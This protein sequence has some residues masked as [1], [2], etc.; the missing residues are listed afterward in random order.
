M[1]P[2]NSKLNAYLQN[3][4]SQHNQMISS[5]PVSDGHVLVKESQLMFL[6]TELTFTHMQLQLGLEDNDVGSPFPHHF[7]PVFFLLLPFPS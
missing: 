5:Q 6:E 2:I 7:L 4:N 3:S 1:H